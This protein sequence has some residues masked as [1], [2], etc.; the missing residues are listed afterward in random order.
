M[1]RTIS[2]D[3]GLM[4]AALTGSPGNI[5]TFVGVVFRR[6]IFQNPGDPKAATERSADGISERVLFVLFVGKAA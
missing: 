4:I 6:F 2:I 5:L 1:K 3:G